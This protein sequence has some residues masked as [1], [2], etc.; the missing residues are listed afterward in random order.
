MQATNTNTCAHM[1]AIQD[2]INIHYFSII[3]HLDCIAEENVLETLQCTANSHAWTW[4]LISL[5]SVL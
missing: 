5:Q 1:I 4:Q 3:A 2:H